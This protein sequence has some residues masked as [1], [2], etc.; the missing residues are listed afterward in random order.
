MDSTEQVWVLDWQRLS[1]E[2]ALERVRWLRD[3]LVVGQDWGVCND[4][5]MCV[6]MNVAAGVMYRLRWF[7]GSESAFQP[8]TYPS[9]LLPYFEDLAEKE[10]RVL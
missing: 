3:N 6:L 5:R 4:P 7:D 9:P 8:H 1:D 2:D 10:E